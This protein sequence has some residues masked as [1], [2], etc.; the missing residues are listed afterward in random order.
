MQIN[1]SFD[2]N[3]T[4][5]PAGFMTAINYVVNYFDSLFTNNVAINVDIGYGEI[6][7][8]SL[9]SNALG[10]SSASYIQESYGAVKSALQARGAPGSASLPSTSPLAG[11]LYMPEAEAQALGLTSA[12]STSYIGFSSTFPFSYAANATPASNQY[13]FIG[14]FEH[15]ITEDMGRASLLDDQPSDYSPMDLFR[16]SSPGVR[17]LSSGGNGS[18]AYFSTDNGATNLGSWNN[19]PSNGDLG[20]WYPSGPAAGGKDAFND[21][22]NSGVINTISANDITLMRDL[23]WTTNQPPVITSSNVTATAGQLFQASSLVS[24]SDPDGDTLTYAFMDT[25]GHGYFDVNGAV[26]PTNQVFEVT[27]SQ[28]GQV[29]FHAGPNGTTDT[30]DANV[31]DGTVWASPYTQFNVTVPGT[32]NQVPTITSSDVTATTGQLFQASSLVSASD[33]DGD[34]LTYALMDATGHGY[35][36]VNGAVQPTNQVF[37]VTQSQLGQVHFH[38]GPNGTTDTIDANVFDGTVWA[39]PYTQFNVTVPGTANQTPTITSSNVT[40][41]AGQLFQASSLVSASDPDGDTLTYAFMDATGLGYFDVNGAVQPTNQVFE[42]TQSQLGQVHFHAGPNGT[43]DTIDANVFDG[44]V[45]A[46]PYTQFK[47]TVPNGSMALIVSPNLT[48]TNSDDRLSTSINSQLHALI[49]ALTNVNVSGNDQLNL[50]A[51]M[52]NLGHGPVSDSPT[53][54]QNTRNSHSF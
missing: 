43:T 29:H 52:D 14:V 22:S 27:Q 40:A 13:Y 39:S 20:D 36:D 30:I 9:G 50:V 4:S 3:Q 17:D 28:L 53:L 6:A 26:Q 31:F 49:D 37:K 25:T 54:T 18:T 16:Y 7:G 46:S 24:A 19:N 10:E 8:Q 32:A 45:W 12:V 34:T 33:P 1:V 21:Y 35:F 41:T 15:E 5:L 2:Q 48:A 51:G 42:V 44:T 11:S 38:A 23:G 47:V